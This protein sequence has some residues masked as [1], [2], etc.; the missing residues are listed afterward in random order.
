VS[1]T[2]IPAALSA[3]TTLVASALP[4]W[5]VF[6]GPVYDIPKNS[7]FACVAFT[8]VPG[9]NS[10]DAS[11]VS[12]DA[13]MSGNT[14]AYNVACVL[15]AHKGTNDLDTLTTTA[16]GALEAVMVAL[17]GDRNLGGAVSVAQ[18]VNHSLIYGVGETGANAT[19][20]FTVQ[21]QA[22]SA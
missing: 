4:S 16:Y 8:G 7:D 21:I 1:G 15:T 6:R 12:V 9:E 22:W 20:P 5:K 3:L 19:V 14:E 10:L 11:V 13:A 2:T 18:L 17:E